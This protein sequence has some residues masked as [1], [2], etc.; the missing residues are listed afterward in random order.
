MY[1]LPTPMTITFCYADLVTSKYVGSVYT[2]LKTSLCLYMC[3]PL[4]NHIHEY[5]RTV[6]K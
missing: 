6:V 3:L 2:D 5:V 4:V 1:W